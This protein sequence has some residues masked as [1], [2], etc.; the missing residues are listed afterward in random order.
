MIRG[1]Y[2]VSYSYIR[3]QQQFVSDPGDTA[4]AAAVQGVKNVVEAAAA[5]AVQ[6]VVL[7]SSMLTHPSNR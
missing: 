3:Q 1:I 7:V 4:A 2:A 6:R 5:G